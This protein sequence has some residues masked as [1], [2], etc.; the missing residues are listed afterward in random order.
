MSMDLGNAPVGTEP[1][2]EEKT[3]LRAAI[4][5]GTA[6][7]AAL[8][9]GT[10]QVPVTGQYIPM[11]VP[12]LPGTNLTAIGPQTNDIASGATI[13]VAKCCYLDSSYFKWKL[14]QANSEITTKGLLVIS[15]EAKNDTQVMNVAL[16]GC[17]VRDNTWTWAIG[18]TIYLSAASGGAMTQ[19]QP[20]AG[21]NM[22]RILGYALTADSIYFNPANE[23]TEI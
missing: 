5:C 2:T 1:T 11:D 18:G 3:Q 12:T 20:A 6:A 4:G 15:L 10:G 8:G 19:T 22:V 7:A 9:T 14:A 21:T 17:I 23:W 13:A 16:P